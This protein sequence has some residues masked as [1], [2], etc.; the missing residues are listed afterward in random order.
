MLCCI[1]ISAH[2][3]SCYAY[4]NINMGAHIMSCIQQHKHGCTHYVMLY[5]IQQHTNS[6][7]HVCGIIILWH[8]QDNVA[9]ISVLEALDM[10]G[11]TPAG[12]PSA[13]QHM[14]GGGVAGS[15]ATGMTGMCVC[16]LLVVCLC[17]LGG[18]VLCACGDATFV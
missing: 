5:N 6:Y 15:G 9:L 8:T 7:T 17:D 11:T 1:H 10:G 13:S 14:H 4:N 3:M 18:G 16:V 12:T 2:I